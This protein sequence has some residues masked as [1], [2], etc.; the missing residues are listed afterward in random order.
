MGCI[1]SSQE[2]SNAKALKSLGTSGIVK[3]YRTVKELKDAM[4]V[5]G[6]M[7]D[8]NVLVFFD[9]TKSNNWTG[10]DTFHGKNLHDVHMGTNRYIQGFRSLKKFIRT[11]QDGHFAL[12]SY[13]SNTAWKQE[14]KV[15]FHG[16]CKSVDGLVST[17][18]AY[19]HDCDATGR[20]LKLKESALNDMAGPTTLKYIIDEGQRVTEATGR[21]H[22][23][24][25]FTDGDPDERYRDEN[26]YEVYDCAK[27]PTKNPMSLVVVGVGDG[28]SYTD[29]NGKPAHG[30]PFY[31]RLD[32]NDAKLMKIRPESLRNIQKRVGMT[33]KPDNF[34]F[35]DLERDI[36]KGAEMTA[37][38]E[39][40]FW[41]SAFMEVPNHYTWLK[42]HGYSPKYGNFVHPT[43]NGAFLAA[44]EHPQPVQQMGFVVPATVPTVPAS[45]PPLPPTAY[46]NAI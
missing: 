20:P 4:Q 33:K 12:Y 1:H 32:D 46:G 14:G 13:G 27:H 24:L 15:L 35:V 45:A 28:I 2:N 30:F 3:N 26:I 21:Y 29:K 22:I 39:D 31:E 40:N 43:P 23:C 8:I 6:V 25:V 10:E 38:L 37:D 16:M 42:K 34:Q 11:D 5:S 36:L 9:M 41:K 18:S 17:Y 19:V 7:E 44:G